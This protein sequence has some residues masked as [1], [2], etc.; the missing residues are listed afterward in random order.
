MIPEIVKENLAVPS[1][2]ADSALCGIVGSCLL[3][4]SNALY[5]AL[6]SGI[7]GAAAVDVYNCEPPA[8]EDY[9]FACREN[10]IATPHIGYY[11]QQAN[12]NSII[13]TTESILQAVGRIK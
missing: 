5:E 6:D 10:V 1:S 3:Y 9:R 2:F 11:T 7:L 4:T 13:M 12:D 8:E